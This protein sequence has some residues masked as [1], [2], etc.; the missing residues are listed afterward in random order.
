[1]QTSG[2]GRP[3]WELTRGCLEGTAGLLGCPLWGVGGLLQRAVCW[4]EGAGEGGGARRPDSQ[5]SGEGPGQAMSEER[6]KGQ[7]WSSR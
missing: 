4:G 7:S 1:M 6:T 5:G 2:E 3:G